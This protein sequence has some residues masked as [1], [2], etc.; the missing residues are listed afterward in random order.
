MIGPQSQAEPTPPV[1]SHHCGLHHRRATLFLPSATEAARTELWSK[2]IVKPLLLT[3]ATGSERRQDS[4]R[5]QACVC[6]GVHSSSLPSPP[7]ERE[8]VVSSCAIH[9]I[10][11]SVTALRRRRQQRTFPA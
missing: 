6:S 9:R 7:R 8:Q 1:K 10:H 5:E 11:S 3:G 2:M 4:Q